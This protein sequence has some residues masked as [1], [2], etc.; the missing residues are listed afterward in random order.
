MALLLGTLLSVLGRTPTP[1]HVNTSS[2]GARVSPELF[3]HDLEFTRHDLFNG[4]SAE[5]LANHKFATLPPA[6]AP[7]WPAAMKMLADAGIGGAPR[8]TGVGSAALDAPYWKNHSGLVDGDVGHSVRCDEGTDP[9]GVE[10]H[11]WLGGFNSGKSFGSSIALEAGKAYVL[12][13][14]LRGAGDGS[15]SVPVSLSSAGAQL[16]THTFAVP[17]ASSGWA[18]VHADV[19]TPA[20]TTNATLRIASTSSSASWW[21]GSA[22]L[23]RA[24]TTPEGLRADVVAALKAANFRG[25]V[26][27]PGGCFATFYRWKLGLLPPDLRPPIATPPSY[28]AAVPG[29]VNAY[30]DGVMANGLGIDE[31]ISLVRELGAVPAITVRVVLGSDQEIAEARDWVEYANGD[32]STPFGALRAKRLGHEEPYNVS[33]WYLGNEIFQARCP[34][35]P[36]D[37][38][39]TGGISADEYAVMAPKF[40]RAMKAASP[41]PLRLISANPQPSGP[42]VAAIGEETYGWSTHGGYYGKLVNFT[43]DALTECAKAPRD[44]FVPQLRANRATLDAAGASHIAISADEWALGWPWLTTTNFSVANGIYA[45][46]FLGSIARAAAELNIA[47]TN[48]FEPINEGAIYV[49]PFSSKLTPVGEAMALMAEHAGGVQAQASTP[50]E[51]LDVLATV[52]GGAN[53][54]GRTAIV[55]VTNLLAQDALGPK[56]LVLTAGGPT[57]LPEQTVQVTVLEAS[58]FA[59]SS[60]FSHATASAAVA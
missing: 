39:C 30:T 34:R 33:V 28:C 11:G 42:W 1:I 49:G 52:H 51:D 59:P 9:C 10:Q 55:T 50:D 26:R 20:T 15:D 4:I 31:Y 43:A 14:V 17:A 45:A 7:G 3:G 46:A 32:T 19:T 8:W 47:F 53:A 56:P 54:G 37:P 18:T 27:Y 21:L 35:Y 23:S 25:P 22:S 38:A 58:G 40:V 12:R 29:G 13:L 5:M 36:A 6:A 24:D 48:D 44:V 57:P 16:W 60:T 41:S 2:P